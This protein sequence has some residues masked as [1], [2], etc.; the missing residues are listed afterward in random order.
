MLMLHVAAAMTLGFFFAAVT[1]FL[2]IFII[3]ARLPLL[4]HVD[5]RASLPLDAASIADTLIHIVA[6][7]I[8]RRYFMLTVVSAAFRH[9][10][11]VATC[12]R[13]SPPSSLAVIFFL[14]RRPLMMATITDAVVDDVVFRCRLPCR[15][16]AIDTPLSSAFH[17]FAA[18]PVVFSLSRCLPRP[19]IR[20][21][22]RHEPPPPLIA[23]IRYITSA[24]FF[25][26]HRRY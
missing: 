18:T 12:P 14:S 1:A 9:C 13:H 3:F 2:L 10:F 7:V 15:N 6:A 16:I 21:S 23:D 8:R 17:I 5:R 25:R 24:I 19:P 11:V 22:L 26:H 20:M 4:R